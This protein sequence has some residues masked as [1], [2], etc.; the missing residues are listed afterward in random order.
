MT[1]PAISPR[2][3]ALDR[4]KH[5]TSTGRIG[6]EGRIWYLSMRPVPHSYTSESQLTG[7]A[8]GHSAYTIFD[9][10]DAWAINRK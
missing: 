2:V 3:L 8:N 4:P 6:S 7:L 10:S 9:Y 5:L 1:P